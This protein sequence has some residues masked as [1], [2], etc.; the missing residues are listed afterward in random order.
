MLKK[1]RFSKGLKQVV[2]FLPLAGAA[3]TIFFPIPQSGQQIS[4]LIVLLWL[5][6]FFVME[7]FLGGI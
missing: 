1:I 7:C 2:K 3:G 5:Q 6:V 4:M